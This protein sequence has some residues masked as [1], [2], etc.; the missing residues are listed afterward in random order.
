M[1]VGRERVR[2]PALGPDL[3]GSAGGSRPRRDGDTHRVR[4]GSAQEQP[5]EHSPT[6]ITEHSTTPGEVNADSC[7]YG[8]DLPTLGRRR[9]PS[10]D[11]SGPLSPPGA[12]SGATTAASSSAFE[13]PHRSPHRGLATRRTAHR[14]TG[15]NSTLDGRYPPSGHGPHSCP[16]PHSP[17]AGRRVSGYDPSHG[18]RRPRLTPPRTRS[19]PRLTPPRTRSVPASPQPR[20]RRA[21]QPVPPH[22]TLNA[23][24]HIFWSAHPAQS[25]RRA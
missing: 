4:P 11:L 19:V 22:P 24:G 7:R 20:T 10:V 17:P 5:A 21:P 1:R 18:G 3:H 8:T 23:L 2:P 25:G 16:N 14:P 13:R 15:H 12:R 9:A 6:T